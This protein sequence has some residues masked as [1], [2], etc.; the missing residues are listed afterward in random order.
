MGL[1]RI[2][3]FSI[4]LFSIAGFTAFLNPSFFLNISIPIKKNPKMSKTAG[5]SAAKRDPSAAAE[6]RHP[7]PPPPPEPLALPATA[8]QAMPPAYT[9]LKQILSS[10]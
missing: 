3:F 2:I 4:Y 1:R 10:R 7:P 5:I 8:V 6:I 9:S